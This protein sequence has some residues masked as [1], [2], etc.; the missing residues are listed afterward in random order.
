LPTLGKLGQ[1]EDLPAAE[2][3]GVVGAGKVGRHG[4]L[5]AA[6]SASSGG[7]AGIRAEVVATGGRPKVGSRRE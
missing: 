3:L 1:R 5:S 4:P 6:R 7:A 2:T